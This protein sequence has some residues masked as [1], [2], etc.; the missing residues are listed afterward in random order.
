M[1]YHRPVYEEW[2]L[3]AY[4]LDVL[5]KALLAWLVLYGF[6]CIHSA[7]RPQVPVPVLDRLGGIVW[8][9]RSAIG[10]QAVLA[11][12]V[13]T[14]VAL[15]ARADFLTDPDAKR[16]RVFFVYENNKIFPEWLFELGA[17]PLARAAREVYGERSTAVVLLSKDS[18]KR[19]LLEG[20]F[21]VVGSHGVRQG[22]LLQDGLL[23][24]EDIERE[25][26]GRNLRYVYLMG[27]DSGELA[28]G[29]RQKLRPAKVV[30]HDRLTAVLEHV[31]WLWME[32]PGMLR[33]YAG[34]EPTPDT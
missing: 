21:V 7:A 9:R 2:L 26:V 13:L 4:V 19:A 27:C 17:L 23:K 14:G 11:L 6:S 33:E 24:P 30:T 20:E 32:S 34:S 25:F 22:L 28:R 8:V 18:L 10:F 29:W 1:I 16:P 31:W 5:W 12:A 3:E 15:T